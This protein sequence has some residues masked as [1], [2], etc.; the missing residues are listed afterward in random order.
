MPL[1][2][3]Q[4]IRKTQKWIRKAEKSGDVA[5]LRAFSRQLTDLLLRQSMTGLQKDESGNVQLAPAKA[6][7]VRAYLDDIINKLQA[8][9]ICP[10]C[11]QHKVVVGLHRAVLEN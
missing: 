1:S 11:G 3:D 4:Q 2:I 5:S 6:E 9:P 7:E 8:G 10:E